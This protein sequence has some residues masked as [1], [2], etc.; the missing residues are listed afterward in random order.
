MQ[1]KRIRQNPTH[2]YELKKLSKIGIEGNFLY[3][4][5]NINKETYI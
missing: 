2:I 4:I 1:K 5:M 3:L